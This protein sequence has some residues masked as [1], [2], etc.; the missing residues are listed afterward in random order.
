MKKILSIVLIFAMLFSISLL[1]A[2]NGQEAEVT[3][4]GNTTSKA[5]QG[6]ANQD[7]PTDEGTKA[8][9]SIRARLDAGEEVIVGCVMLADVPVLMEVWAGQIIDILEPEG[10]T[11]NITSADGDMA[12]MIS[13]IENF[14]TM[15]VACIITVPTDA[16]TLN[17]IAKQAMAEGVQILT[18]GVEESDYTICCRNDSI[19]KARMMVYMGAAW[20][21]KFY[22]EVNEDNKLK[23]A[24]F[25]ENSVVDK[26]ASGDAAAETIEE[27]GIFDNVYTQI[28]D[29]SGLDDSF[30][31]GE[32]A[33]TYDPEIRVFFAHQYTAAMGISNYV[34]SQP[35]LNPAEYGVFSMD[36]DT[37]SV[38]MIENLSPKNE[39]I[40]RGTTIPA[41]SQGTKL[42]EVALQ[43]IMEDITA[44]QLFQ[45]DIFAHTDGTYDFSV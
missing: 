9:D 42:G 12:Q 1:C 14:L 3:E 2:C 43:V 36:E 17:E 26:I 24:F 32:N 18:W 8:S 37:A 15:G 20:V 19:T 27:V 21:A 45:V 31:A 16:A 38:D 44:P 29:T 10:F 23:V 13:Q 6:E 22:P 34:M 39:A 41:T 28:G 25:R 11:M 40:F 5:N 30:V 35:E 33:L 4:N 7:E